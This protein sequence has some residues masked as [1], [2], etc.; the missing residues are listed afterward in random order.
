MDEM[1]S[2]ENPGRN[3]ISFRAVILGVV[4][5]LAL[6]MVFMALAAGFGLWNFDIHGYQIMRPTIWLFT[7]AATSISLFAGA[8][9]GA[10]ASRTTAP[11]DGRL[12]GF[13]IW[14]F[15]N[16][17]ICFFIYSQIVDFAIYDID[18]SMYMAAFL[19][20]CFAAIAAV[21]GGAMGAKSEGL[22]EERQLETKR[23]LERAKLNEAYSH[24]Y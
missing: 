16:V 20:Q 18:Q 19:G 15:V 10:I 2:V 1:E 17:L 9:S 12:T 5:S 24:P 6:I 23:V 14:S 7:Y 22:F 21:A 13:L 4:H 8:Y 11:R 3:R